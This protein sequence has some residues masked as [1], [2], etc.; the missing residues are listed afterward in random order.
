APDPTES[1]TVAWLR[2][3][4]P[5]RPAIRDSNTNPASKGLHNCASSIRWP[6]GG[7]GSFCPDRRFPCH[8]SAFEQLPQLQGRCLRRSRGQQ[9][10]DNTV[11]EPTRSHYN[12]AWACSVTCH[13]A[14]SYPGPRGQNPSIWSES[15]QR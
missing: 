12:D 11:L 10:Y 6:K 15:V 5:R 14:S 2:G 9:A 3:N 1:E 7:L 4:Q 13:C 8:T